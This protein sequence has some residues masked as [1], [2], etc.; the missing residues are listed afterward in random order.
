MLAHQ[1]IGFSGTDSAIAVAHHVCD[2]LDQ[3][4]EPRDISTNIAGAN[5]GIDGRRLLSSPSTAR[6]TDHQ[7]TPGEESR[8]SL[9]E[10]V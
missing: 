7:K 4:M 3:G 5:S 10:A 8:G 1:G 2:A 6:T 9:C